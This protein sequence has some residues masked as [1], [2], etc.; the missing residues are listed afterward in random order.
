[1]YPYVPY[2][3]TTI[4]LLEQRLP[5]LRFQCEVFEAASFRILFSGDVTQQVAPDFAA[6]ADKLSTKADS[7]LVSLDDREFDTGMARV[8][9]E[10]K[11]G[12]IVEPIDFVVFGK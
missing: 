10:T 3:P 4:P 2:F 7:I 6:Y 12:P 1:M 9:A 11:P 5:S 8:R